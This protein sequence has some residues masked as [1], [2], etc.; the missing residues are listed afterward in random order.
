MLFV[1][2]IVESVRLLVEKP[3]KL[4]TDIEG[5][6]DISNNW[7]VGGQTRHIATKCTYLRELKEANIIKFVLVPGETMRADL[8]T[9][10]LD[11]ET[12]Q[13]HAAHFIGRPSE[14]SN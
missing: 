13:W 1:M 4:Y 5:V 9:K 10:K 12:F 3:M 11:C 2:E 14:P 8:F 6:F 7:I